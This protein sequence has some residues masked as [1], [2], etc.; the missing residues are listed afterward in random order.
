MY[1]ICKL[2]TIE[3]F[4]SRQLIN[5]VFVLANNVTKVTDIKCVTFIL[6]SFTQKDSLI[7]F[8]IL[9]INNINSHNTNTWVYPMPYFFEIAYCSQT[10]QGHRHYL[11]FSRSRDVIDHV[12]IGIA[13]GY[14]LLAVIWNP[15]SISNGFRDIRM[16]IHLGHALTL[17]WPSTVTRLHRAS[18]YLIS[19]VL[20]PI[21]APL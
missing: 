6:Q 3:R 10:Y 5:P 15:A 4:D 13:M 9:V 12:T 20:F 16:Q 18:D 11:N 2:H 7:P 8:I 1:V 14:F 21:G 17:P 19:Q